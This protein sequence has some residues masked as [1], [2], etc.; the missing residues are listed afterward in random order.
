MF[1]IYEVS[2]PPDEGGVF[3]IYDTGIAKPGGVFK[4]YDT[5]IIK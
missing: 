5:G 2:E 1:L 4:L 3:K